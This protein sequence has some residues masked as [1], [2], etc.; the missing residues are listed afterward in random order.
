MFILTFWTSLSTKSKQLSHTTHAEYVNP[1]INY[2]RHNNQT[3]QAAQ[4]H[5][6]PLTTSS[7]TASRFLCIKLTGGNV[8]RF[9]YN[10]HP[11]ATSSFLLYLF[12]RSEREPVC[13]MN[14]IRG[15]E[16]VYYVHYLWK[17]TYQSETHF[18]LNH[19]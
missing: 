6:V 19:G 12:A 11:T 7:V 14:H 10:E 5:L 8:E 3:L 4:V 1:W 18:E 15:C 16:S 13:D 17:D 9:G 2:H